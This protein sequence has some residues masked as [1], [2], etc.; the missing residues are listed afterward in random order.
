MRTETFYKVKCE[1]E[2][3]YEFLKDRISTTGITWG[4]KSTGKPLHIWS[5]WNEESL[6]RK[7]DEGNVPYALKEKKYREFSRKEFSSSYVPEGMEEDFQEE[8]ER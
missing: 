5:V 4:Q 7:L 3:D 1:R 8:Q 6:R 2:G